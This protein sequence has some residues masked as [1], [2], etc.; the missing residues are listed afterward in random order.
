MSNRYFVLTKNIPFEDERELHL[1]FKY[2]LEHVVKVGYMP[3]SNESNSK[4]VLVSG[5]D[6][7]TITQ[8]FGGPNERFIHLYHIDELPKL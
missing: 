3:E 1:Q 4:D 5:R 7:E 8:I 6:G 2:H